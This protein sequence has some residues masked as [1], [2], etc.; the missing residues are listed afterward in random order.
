MVGVT[1]RVRQL[2]ERICVPPR[3]EDFTHDAP[4]SPRRIGTIYRFPYNEGGNMHQKGY[5]I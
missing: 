1:E 3:G 2:A 5:R 4:G